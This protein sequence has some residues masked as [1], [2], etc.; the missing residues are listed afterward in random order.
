MTFPAGSFAFLD[1]EMHHYAMASREVIVLV[2]GMSPLEFNYVNPAD[3][4]SKK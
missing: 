4:P 3:D 1:P 2:H